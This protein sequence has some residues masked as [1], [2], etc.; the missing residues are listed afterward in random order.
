VTA[1]SDILIVGAGPTGLA[2]ALFL[3][4]RGHRARILDRLVDPS[5]WSKAFGV[6]ARSLS[7]L[8]SSGVTESYVANGRK[9]ERL[10]LHRHGRILTTLRLNEVADRFPFMLVQSQAD[11][12]RLM[13]KALS[14]RGITVER[15]TEV[16]GIGKDG[17]TAIVDVRAGGIDTRIRANCVLDAGGA[18]SLVRK[19]LKIPFDG[20]AYEEPWRLFDVELDALPMPH[21]DA[22][23]LLH[24]SGGIFLVREYDNIWR[25][26]G[27]VPDMLNQL[28]QGTKVGPIHWESDFEIANRVAVRF[29]DPPY[30]I[31][32]DAAHTHAG[33]GARGMNLGVEDA[34]VFA[35]L[36][37]R[38]QL[39]RYDAMRRPL[40]EKLVGQIKRAMGPPRP[41]TLSGRVVRIAPWLVPIVV[42]AFRTPIQRWILGLDH[43]VGL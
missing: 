18:N 20:E 40:V 29:A 32:G 5:P 16:I 34:Y 8:E 15:G 22:N 25:V 14:E 35:T 42:G 12:E 26:L 28:P 38:N 7:L 4:E 41:S 9:M 31:A 19:A 33:I 13:E 21:E 2:A 24:D 17:A 37:D 10:N 23:V 36:F 43:E 6:N 27:N 39:E 1:Q 3:A 11:S 30:Y